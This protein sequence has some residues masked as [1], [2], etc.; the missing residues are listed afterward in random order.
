MPLAQPAPESTASTTPAVPA[1][2]Q[3]RF[4]VLVMLFFS[5]VIAYM[6]RINIS[7]VAP[8][9]MQQYGWSAATMGLVFSSF[10]W[11][12][13]AVQVLGGWIADRWGGRRVLTFALGGWSVV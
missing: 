11:A 5:I 8:A 9:V 13:A 6:D 3:R 10:F 1:V 4:T 7:V 2:S 12:Y